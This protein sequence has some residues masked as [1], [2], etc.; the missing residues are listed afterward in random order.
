MFLLGELWV[1]DG[2]ELVVAFVFV[3]ARCRFGWWMS[4]CVELNGSLY[5]NDLA[6]VV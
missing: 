5:I 2:V 6:G 4:L 3:C 1:D